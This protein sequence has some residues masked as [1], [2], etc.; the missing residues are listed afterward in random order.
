MESDLLA[1]EEGDIDQVELDG[2]DGE[3]YRHH[4]VAEKHL[5][6]YWLDAHQETS[7]LALRLTPACPPWT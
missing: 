5:G 1:T 7:G 3:S 4:A 6:M 2:L